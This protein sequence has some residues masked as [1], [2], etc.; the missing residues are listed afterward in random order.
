MAETP[1]NPTFQIPR[2]VIE[3]IIQA[4]VT[5]AV[6]AALGGHQRLVADA[7]AQVLN[8]KVDSSGN[9]SRYNSSS[10]PTFIQWALQDCVRR[11]TQ[12]AIEAALKDH[13]EALRKHLVASLQQKNSPLVKQ[14]VEG[15]M[16]VLASPDTLR[17]RL[18]VEYM[19]R[20]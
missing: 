16:G 4:H 10:D 6:T 5:T 15:M 14:L 20:D 18:K 8:A 13:Q 1:N 3:P 9:P 2:D 17:Y 7:I 19:G 11:A 12:A